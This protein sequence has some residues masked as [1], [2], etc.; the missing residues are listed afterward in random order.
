MSDQ[1]QEQKKHQNGA[2]GRGIFAVVLLGLTLLLGAA[3]TGGFLVS[4]S[5]ISGLNAT[6]FNALCTLFLIMLLITGKRWGIHTGS[7]ILTG[8]VIGLILGVGCGFKLEEQSAQVAWL[9]DIFLNSLN[10][11]IIPLVVA[12]LI[13]GITNLGD[14]RRLGEV[15]L[16][17]VLYYVSTTIISVSIGI[18]LVNIMNPGLQTGVEQA[19]SQAQKTPDFIQS[20]E[21][22]AQEAIIEVITNMVPSNVVKAAS[23]GE[24]LPLI[25][26][27]LVFGIVLTVIGRKGETVVRFFQGVNSAVMK[28][29]HWIL[30]L[31]PVGVFGL[32][33]G[34]IGEKGGG[35]QVYEIIMR[36]SQFCLT[37][38]AGLV[39]HSLVVLP[40][41]LLLV[42]RR[43]PL[44]YMRNM[45]E[46]FVTAVST[47][48]SSGTLPVTM[49]CVKEKN[50]VGEEA[51]DLVLPLGAT[52]NMDGTALYEATA[53]I[54]IAQTYGHTLPFGQQLVVFLAATLAAVG[55]AGIPHAG[56]V[57]MAIVLKAVGLPL[58]K[59][60]L[61]LTVDWFLDRCRTT[62]NV[63][64]DS[65]GAAVVDRLT[66]DRA[67]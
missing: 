50:Q 32:V 7:L 36:I 39:I 66:S 53:V 26:F 60:G 30:W 49:E 43:N 48:S 4:F 17:T 21:Q 13:V 1:A 42:A 47:A 51:S 56:L 64:G 46:A 37:V 52:I 28:L 23:E 8:I 38:M 14:V 41:I 12:S 35:S 31:A 22:T 16:M 40:L 61:L 6:T 62:V 57:T 59:I 3:V 2:D 33:A 65:V 25:V 34:I 11:I 55:A 54:F 19:Q 9:G 24:I 29:V 5:S 15:G 20:G 58:D 27:A 63:F 44:T 67:Q 10:M 45:L 18:G